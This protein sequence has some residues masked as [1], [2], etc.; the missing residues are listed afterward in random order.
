M[1]ELVKKAQDLIDYEA[2]GNPEIKEILSVVE[3]FLKKKKVLCYGGTAINNLLP[4]EDRFYDPLYDI[5]DYDFYS[6][7]PQLHALE[8]ADRF[9]NLG[10]RA[11]EVKPG[12]HLMTFKVFVNYTGVA[13]ITYLEPP[14]FEKLWKEDFHREG[15]HYVSPNFLRMSM[16][17]EI[18][19]PR[20]DVSRWSKVYKRLLL[21]NKHYPIKCVPEEGGFT[22]IG[23]TERNRVEKFLESKNAVLLGIHAADFH[24]KKKTNVWQVPID[25]LVEPNKFE[26]T[27]EEFKEIFGE[28]VESINRP[29]Y[30]ELLPDHADIVDKDSKFLLVRIFKSFACHSY[31]KVK[32][33][34]VASIPTLLQFFFAFVYASSHFLEGFDENRIVC[35]CQ[36]LVDL[37]HSE[38]KRRFELLTPL[39]CLGHQETLVEIKSHKGKLY[40]STSKRSP[41]FLRLFFSYTPG[42]MSKTQKQKL[43]DRLR[44]TMK[45]AHE[46]DELVTDKTS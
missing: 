5:P 39:D 40:N 22:T 36:R 18:S 12:T 43:K 2:A 1:E 28:R 16:Y 31:H 25:I 42:S 20:G 27:I 30:A 17:L 15:I 33:I 35:I 41:E 45:K 38:G 10:F 44:K 8:L 7:E 21:L 14:I 34:H 37:A 32:D 23:E 3:D 4:S 19:R 11:I 29:H 24:S 46:I 6:M 13:D 9:Y 26:K